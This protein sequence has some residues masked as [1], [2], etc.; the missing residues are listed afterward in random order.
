VGA[1][2]GILS[3]GG[4]DVA[5]AGLADR[6][7][8]TAV[9]ETTRLQI[10]SL[11]KPMV[12]TV[13]ARLAAE[14]R[15]RFDDRIPTH[16]PEL[17]A[18]GWAERV[19]ILDLLANRSGVP[20]S[21]AVEFAFDAEGDDCLSR[22]A[23]SVAEQPPAFA[24]GSAW[25][26]CN[27]A[28]CLLGRAIETVCGTTWEEAMRRELFEPLNMQSTTFISEG[29]V[30]GG[31]PCYSDVDGETT[32]VPPWRH[33]ALGPAGATIWST[34]PDLLGFARLH[35]ADDMAL[36]REVEHRLALPDFMDAWCRGWA[37]WDWSGG[38]V[39]GWCGVAAGHRAILQLIP[40]REAAI[41]L[42]T[43]SSRGRELYRH[44]FPTVLAERFG[45]TMPPVERE[46]SGTFA[47]D[48]P[49]YT[50]TYGWPDY[51]FTVR[52]DRDCLRV[53]SPELDAEASP[54]TPRV[55]ALT[56]GD[57]DVPVLVF[58]DFGADRRPQLLY[59]AVW[60]YPRLPRD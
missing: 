40:H 43:N 48:L 25:S 8:A 4:V 29:D 34:L 11:T 52:A 58:E 28:W 5:Y 31:A 53:A 24:P 19:T 22:L 49:S 46:P 23:A 54:V 56:P 59:E 15:L 27:T 20:M 6:E 44:V 18:S 21:A 39:W 41:V 50:G 55:F 32:A 38:P 3:G 57:P 33:R 16:I 12:A 9:D 10:A 51:E 47:V 7:R 60:A 45:V 36:L 17:R 2:L 37:R 42:T 14:D 30:H 35:L 26:Y 1:A 13:I